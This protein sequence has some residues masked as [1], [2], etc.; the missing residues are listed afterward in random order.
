M[1]YATRTVVFKDVV[2]LISHYSRKLYDYYGNEKDDWTSEFELFLFEMY[3]KE[4]C[5]SKE[6]VAVSLRHYYY[7]LSKEKSKILNNEMGY[8]ENL[9]YIHTRIDD[10]AQIENRTDVKMMLSLLNDKQKEVLILHYCYGYSIK[11]IATYKGVS[12]QAINRTK[13]TAIQLIRDRM[14]ISV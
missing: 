5:V 1:N 6:Y 11:K 14:N 4:N 13:N 3:E 8:I 10:F 2:G 12:R 7:Y 9:G